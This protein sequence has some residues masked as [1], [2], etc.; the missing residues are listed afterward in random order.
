MRR[1]ILSPP[2]SRVGG[3]PS[4]DHAYVLAEHRSDPPPAVDSAQSDLSAGHETEHQDD[5]GV[6]IRQR[7]LRLHPPAELFMEPLNRIRG[8]QRL[9]LR[10][11]EA[12]EREQ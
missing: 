5:G 12:N 4:C 3:I 7:A 1:F 10:F 11:G 8:S 6:F 9:P 2:H